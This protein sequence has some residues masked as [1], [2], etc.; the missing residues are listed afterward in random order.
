[1]QLSWPMEEAGLA[2]RAKDSHKGNFGHLL[3]MGGDLGMAGAVRLCGEAAARVGCGLVSVVTQLAHVTAL[4]AARPELM[5][6]GF[7][8][9]ENLQD[10]LKKVDLIAIGPGLGQSEW[11]RKLWEIA[12]G[13][14]LPLVVDAD[15]LNM[16][17]QVHLRN[18]H[19]ILTPHVGEAGRLL[20]CTAKE[21]QADRLTAALAIQQRYG[22]VC[23][24]KGQNSLIVDGIAPAAACPFGNPGMASGGMGDVLTG[25]IA[26]LWAQGLS[27]G[28]AARWGVML[29]ARA[30]DVAAQEGERGLLALDLMPWLRRGVNDATAI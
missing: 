2:P 18:D 4:V 13:S 20:G 5:C 7:S 10:L 3:V 24:L 21:V 19:W 9:K 14:G 6:H 11:G 26:G 16:L 27:P 23:V 25:V 15:A 29:H 1:M 17:A 8:S 28:A 30:G 12:L 22:G